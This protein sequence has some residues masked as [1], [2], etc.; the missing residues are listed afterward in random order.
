[1]NSLKLIKLSLREIALDS[2]KATV[3]NSSVQAIWAKVYASNEEPILDVVGKS[4][5]VWGRRLTRDACGE[6]LSTPHQHH[7]QTST[8]PD[9]RA[10]PSNSNDFFMLI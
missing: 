2:F 5:S 3:L 7:R 9:L 8:F 6:N 1:M 10:R 4:G